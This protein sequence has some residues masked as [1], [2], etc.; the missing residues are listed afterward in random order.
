MKV[1]KTVAE[2][3]QLLAIPLS[4]K[5]VVGFAPTMGAL[6]S[7][8]IALV[9]R[10]RKECDAVAVSI[11]VNPT[12][13]NDKNDLARYP[14]TL[15]ADVQLLQAA[16]CDVVFAPEVEEIYPTPDTRV[17]DFGMLDKVMEGERR[18]G[19]FNGV[20]Q[21]VSRLFDIVKP[22][23][24]YFGEKDFQQLAIV[25]EL[26]HQ[27]RY[28]VEIVPCPIVREADGLAM[29]SR[30]TLLT[31]EQRAAAP[32]IAKTLFTAVD[33]VC[34]TDLATLKKFVVDQIEGNQLLKLEYFDVVNTKTLQPVYS[35]D[36]EG[37]K[38]AC[39]AVQAGKIRLIDNMRIS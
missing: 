5:E 11:F 16:G 28:K 29:S 12:Q 9:K 3:Q 24:A 6:H 35:L 21:V 10:A 8:H 18:P 38:Q 26:V 23:R 7:G 2:V 25:R 33:M 34:E 22:T 4:N 27:L 17:F 36:N 20:G 14:R 37:S 31:P 30:N 1:V 39:I 32:L 15:D 19:H 13:F